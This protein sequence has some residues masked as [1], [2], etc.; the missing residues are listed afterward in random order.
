[1]LVA[2]CVASRLAKSAAGAKANAAKFAKLAKIK[3][4]VPITH[5]FDFVLGGLVS[6]FSWAL[7]RLWRPRDW[8]L[9]PVFTPMEPKRPKARPRS[10]VESLAIVGGWGVEGGRRGGGEERGD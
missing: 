8:R 5:S 10:Q 3:S 4:A 9:L 7:A 6:S 1:M 2:N